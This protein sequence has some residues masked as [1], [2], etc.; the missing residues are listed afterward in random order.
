MIFDESNGLS[1]SVARLNDANLLRKVSKFSNVDCSPNTG[2]LAPDEIDKSGC[3]PLTA[4]N[5]KKKEIKMWNR[6][7]ELISYYLFCRLYLNN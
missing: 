4:D 1:F 5:Y 6:T 7:I 3:R 2:L